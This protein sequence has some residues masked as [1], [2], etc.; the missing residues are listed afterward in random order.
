[1]PLHSA[2]RYY[3][4]SIFDNATVLSERRILFNDAVNG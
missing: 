2:V 3:S 1:M 4:F